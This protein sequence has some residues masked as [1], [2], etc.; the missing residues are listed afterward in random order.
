MDW[1]ELVPDRDQLT[2][3][4]KMIVNLRVSSNFRKFL[5]S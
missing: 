1:I 2:A 3:P 4:V 5:S